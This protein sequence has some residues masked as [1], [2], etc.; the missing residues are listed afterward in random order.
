MNSYEEARQLF[1]AT[2][3]ELA[4]KDTASLRLV[5]EEYLPFV[6]QKV[7]PAIYAANPGPF[8]TAVLCFFTLKAE[9]HLNAICELCE[10]GLGE[11]AQIISRAIYE[12]R[13][14]LAWI[15]LPRTSAGRE[16]RAKCFAYDGDRQRLGKAREFRKMRAAG[17]C[18]D[19]IV[20]AFEAWPTAQK[21]RKPRAFKSLP[22]LKDMATAVGGD[23]ECEY[24]ALYW[25]VSKLAHPS[26]LGT[27]TYL[28]A[29]PEGDVLHEAVAWAIPVHMQLTI[30]SLRLAKLRDLQQELDGLARQFIAIQGDG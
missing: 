10:A 30:N 11:D 21:I 3:R 29:E 25:S 14:H 20:E 19:W 4:E 1:A 5:K 15:S 28:E 7:L 23:L 22:S 16:Y 17:Q 26:G 2:K 27:S 8:L 24:H 12:H 18:P 13:V 9:R 6:A